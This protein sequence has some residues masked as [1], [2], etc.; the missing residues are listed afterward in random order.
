MISMIIVF[1]LMGAIF[2]ATFCLLGIFG[3][4][5]GGF[6]GIIG[7][8]ILGILAITVFGI[9]F[10]ALPLIIILGIAAIIGAIVKTT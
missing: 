6:L 1:L 9:G 7:Y 5:I 2:K 10:F 3:R 8:L 4:I